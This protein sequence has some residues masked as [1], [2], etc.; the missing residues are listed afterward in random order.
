MGKVGDGLATGKVVR[1]LHFNYSGDIAKVVD[2]KQVDITVQIDPNT[3]RDQ[4]ASRSAMSEVND[5]FE[6]IAESW[7]KK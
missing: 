3:G 2:R 4:I 7:I 1:N 5:M 6:R